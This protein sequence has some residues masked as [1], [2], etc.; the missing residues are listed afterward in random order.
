MSLESIVN[1]I[2]DEAKAQREIILKEAAQQAEAILK[3]AKQQAEAL[4]KEVIN[5]EKTLAEK[6]R[7]KILVNARLESKKSLLGARQELLDEVFKD[8]KTKLAKD[9]FKKEQIFFDKVQE[10]A[11][12]IDFYLTEIRIDYETEVARILFTPLENEVF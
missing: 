4:F 6:Q 7:Q 8:L 10:G 12:D 1:H 11:L 2:L 5:Q 9:R 3:E